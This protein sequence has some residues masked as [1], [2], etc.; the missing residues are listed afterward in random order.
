MHEHGIKTH[1]A[2]VP[3]RLAKATR[4]LSNGSTVA[5]WESGLAH[6]ELIAKRMDGKWGLGLDGLI[7]LIPIAGDIGTLFVSLNIVHIAYKLKVPTLKLVAM[8]LLIAIDFVIGWDLFDIP[9]LGGNKLLDFVFQSNR[10][11]VWIMKH[12][13]EQLKR[14][15]GIPELGAGE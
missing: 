15:A 2:D 6:A 3:Q 14:E 7:G 13:F 12:H 4:V 11:N 9:T 10:Y 8:L 5:E 1:E